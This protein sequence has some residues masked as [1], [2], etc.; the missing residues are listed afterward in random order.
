MQ[1]S[2][3]TAPFLFLILIVLV[4]NQSAAAFIGIESPSSNIYYVD[5]SHPQASDTNP[6]TE[7]LPWFTIQHA[8]DVLIAGET[9]IIKPGFYAERVIPQ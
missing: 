3:K 4:N 6:G 1:Y 9:V 8:A 5:Q 7:T 2:K